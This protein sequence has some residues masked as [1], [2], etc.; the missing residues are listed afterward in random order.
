MQKRSTQNSIL[1]LT[2]LGVYLGLV[3]VVATPQVLAQAATARQFDVKE[4]IEGRDNLDNKPDDERSPV[5][6]SLTIYLGDVEYFLASLSN[7]E[8]KGEFD[9]KTDTFYVSQKS[10]VPCVG[11]NIAG[12][13]SPIRFD[14]TSKLP[15][16]TI[17]RFS[18]GMTY[19]YSLGD[20]L[21][22]NQFNGTS[23]VDSNFSFQLDSKAFSITVTIKK[24]SSNRAL[25]IKR[26]LESTILLYSAQTNDKVRQS[27]IRHTN[28]RAENNQVLVVTN[29]P[30]S[31]LDDLLATK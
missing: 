4:E 28:F 8:S 9:T 12:S 26:E 17:K 18:E 22:N 16:S 7:L 24:Q 15:Q 11:T 1:F 3:L 14:G 31:D 30:R 25:E 19:G 23:A 6:A 2:T 10:M 29:L 5:S 21:P 13:Y 20:C 27:I